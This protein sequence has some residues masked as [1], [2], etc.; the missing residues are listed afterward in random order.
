MDKQAR[1]LG[2]AV[3][4]RKGSYN[5]AALWAAQRLAPNNATIEIFELLTNIPPYNQDLG[6]QSPKAVRILRQG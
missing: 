3:G 6:N 2:I 5:R 4:R 1:I